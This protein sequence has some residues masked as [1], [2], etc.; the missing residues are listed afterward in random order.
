MIGIQNSSIKKK[1]NLIF[2]ETVALP[3]SFIVGV[4]FISG[5]L[6][7]ALIKIN[8]N[9]KNWCLT[10]K[11]INLSKVTILEIPLFKS[12]GAATLNT[13][14]LGTLIT[15]CSLLQDFLASFKS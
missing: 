10:Y 9:V 5:S 15:F 4:S 11:A 7:G 8:L 3:I 6:T 1:V 14:E 13:L 12:W 2:G